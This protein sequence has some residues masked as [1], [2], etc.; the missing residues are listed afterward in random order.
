M[1]VRRYI[2]NPIA[3]PFEVTR[4]Y[5]QVIY[6]QTSSPRV[7]KLIRKWDEEEWGEWGLV[8]QRQQLAYVI[9]VELLDSSPL[10]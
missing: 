1:L 3:K 8:E 10:L 7:D 5:A 9:L 4:E 2:P 6:N